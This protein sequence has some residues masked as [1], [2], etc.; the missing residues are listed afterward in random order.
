MIKMD[1]LVQKLS[2]NDQPVEVTVRPERTAQRLKECLDRGY[3][4][5]KFTKTKGGTE[6]G[7]TIDSH[8]SDFSQAD[9]EKGSGSIRIV[10]RLTLNYVPVRC[11][12]RVDIETFQGSGHLEPTAPEGPSGSEK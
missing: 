8:E 3:V 4:H 6:L 12:A 1:E 5:V 10:G 2:Q 7:V 9:F 11:V